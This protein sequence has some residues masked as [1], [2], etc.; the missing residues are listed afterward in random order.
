MFPPS[1]RHTQC[2]QVAPVHIVCPSNPRSDET[3]VD[4]QRNL[5]GTTIKCRLLAD[6]LGTKSDVAGLWSGPRRASAVCA[7]TSKR[8]I[9]VTSLQI[10]SST[11][12]NWAG[13]VMFEMRIL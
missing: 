8:R 13:H 2:H 11:T 5:H 10:L 6:C 9:C 7:S 3:I 1:A 4:T 12:L